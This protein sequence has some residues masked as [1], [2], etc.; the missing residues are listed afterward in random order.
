MK[1]KVSYSEPGKIQ[2]FT[3]KKLSGV[4]VKFLG[5]KSNGE[6]RYLLTQK[7][8]NKIEHLCVFE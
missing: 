4:G 7:A 6:C 8:Y 5:I 1:A 3:Q 2:V